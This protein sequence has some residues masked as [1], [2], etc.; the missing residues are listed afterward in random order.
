MLGA[1]M[2]TPL[3]LTSLLRRAGALFGE[4]EVVSRL[5][6]KQLL[7]STYGDLYR[8]S[9]ALAG[10]LSAAG[11]RRGDRVATLMWNHRW[12]LEAYFGVPAAG[13]VLHTLNLRL[14]PDELAYI[15]NHAEDRFLIAD[16]VLLP[17]YE[18]FC[19]KTRFER[20]IVVPTAES[21][22]AGSACHE[23]YEEFLKSAPPSYDFPE[24]HDEN[25]AAAM[26]Y[27]SGT[28]GVPKGVVYSHRSMVLHTFSAALP[29]NHG[30][31]QKDCVLPAV[32]MFHVL[33]WGMPYCAAMT[34]SKLVLPG[35]YLDAQSLLELFQSEQVTHSAGVPTIWMRVLEELD[36]QLSAWKLH[37]RLRIN[38]GGSAVPRELIR[39]L[40]RHQIT[41]RHA[42]GMTET[43]P[44][45]SVCELK[46]YMKNWPEE[47]RLDVEVKQGLP[48]PMIEARVANESGE[49]P[50]DGE[51]MGELQ[52]RGPWV[53]ASYY[54]SP[55]LQEEKWTP[56]GWF[57][58]GDVVT[59]DSEGYIRIA[60]RTK[61]LI[62]SGGE[63]ISSVDLENALMGHP[64][65]FEA[66][67]IAAPHPKWVE[68]PLAAVVLK[69]GARATPEELRAHLAAG[70][71]AWQL[72]DAIVF[73]DE[74]P[75]T[76]VGKMKKSR[77]REMFTGWDWDRSAEESE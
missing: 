7:R 4:T 3:T 69:Q 67:V 49:A 75:R 66:A 24:I 74:I 2:N 9:H 45:A 20:V 5:P 44:L 77:L 41:L 40:A 30:L 64:A 51:T 60:D 53:A 32:P 73:V 38:G 12:H 71:A 19:A 27:T 58:T 18:R 59:I 28:T 33:S 35:Q 42:W 10:A 47:Q 68:R 50:W 29:D 72:P 37:P 16:D 61:D 21:E 55:E 1:M 26:C 15:A 17:L 14:H 65:V 70:F 8:R 39:G 25:Q 11:L 54:K 56:D 36:R 62:K 22:C 52:V 48:V 6:S 34:G 57:C 76:S 31:S 23:N 13:G 46:P 63:W 43:G